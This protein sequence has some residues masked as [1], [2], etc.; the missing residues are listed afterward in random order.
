[1]MFSSSKKKIIKDPARLAEEIEENLQTIQEI[2]QNARS[3]KA[4]LHSLLASVE[5][6]R[7]Q[8][9][10]EKQ[11]Q[12]GIKQSLVEMQ[13]LFASVKETMAAAL[14]AQ[15]Q[16]RRQDQQTKGLDERLARIEKALEG[17]GAK[18][19]FIA[20]LAKS[21]DTVLEKVN[22]G[23]SGALLQ[24]GVKALAELETR[25]KKAMETMTGVEKTVAGS[26]SQVSAVA[27]QVRTMQGAL[28]TAGTR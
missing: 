8:I 15:E 17:L 19:R 11:E 16:L 13:A 22:A 3:E 5:N 1:M 28:E 7:S 23:K 20:D 26:F 12:S 4:E 27:D 10:A 9:M 2:V 6:Q 24:E 14:A 25:Q 18:E 21:V